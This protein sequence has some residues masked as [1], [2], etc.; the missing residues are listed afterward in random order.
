MPK[1][2][3]PNSKVNRSK[4]GVGNRVTIVTPPSAQAIENTQ[5]LSAQSIETARLARI[6]HLVIAQRSAANVIS[7]A[8]TEFGAPSL[9]APEYRM[10]CITL[11]E[12]DGHLQASRSE[13]MQNSYKEIA[14]FI[15][16]LP[17][18]NADEAL[19]RLQDFLTQKGA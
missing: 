13:G 5:L 3:K 15:T 17:A 9:N 4:R 18:V 11:A 19:D 14:D 8:Y 1:K 6:H 12:L 7:S 10:V 16:N 2:N